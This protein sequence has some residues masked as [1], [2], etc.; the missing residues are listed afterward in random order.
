[1]QKPKPT[2]RLPAYFVFGWG[3]RQAA[4]IN[5]AESGVLVSSLPVWF[6]FFSKK[7]SPTRRIGAAAMIALF[8][9]IVVVRII[10]RYPLPISHG[11]FWIL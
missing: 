4:M 9:F 11:I 3:C 2:R 10:F 5:S 7:S 6:S 1:M 8:A